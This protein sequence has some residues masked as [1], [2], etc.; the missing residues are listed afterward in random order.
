M[1]WNNP[2]IYVYKGDNSS[3]VIKVAAWPGVAK[4]KVNNKLYSYIMSEGFVD[5]KVIFSNNVSSQTPALGAEGHA[6]TSGSVM[7]Y[8]NGTWSV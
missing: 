3:S 8:N 5:A 6:L 2:N 1:N 7:E 4:T